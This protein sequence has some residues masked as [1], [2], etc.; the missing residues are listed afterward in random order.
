MRLLCMIKPLGSWS[1]KILPLL[2]S[3]YSIY[4][5]RQAVRFTTLL[6]PPYNPLSSLL[7]GSHWDTVCN[8]PPYNISFRETGL[9]E[10]S[11]YSTQI[12]A[13]LCSLCRFQWKSH[14]QGSEMIHGRTISTT[15]SILMLWESSDVGFKKFFFYQFTYP[16]FLKI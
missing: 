15:V 14:S 12:L 9:L 13:Y 7:F 6:M 5:L 3:L 2:K 4:S 1:C 11:Y 16:A 10:K 8:L